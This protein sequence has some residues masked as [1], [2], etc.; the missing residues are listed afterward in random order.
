MQHSPIHS[1]R[2]PRHN[3]FPVQPPYRGIYAHGVEVPAGARTLHVSGQVGVTPSGHLAEGFQGQCLQAMDNVEAV[4]ASAEMTKEDIVKMSF[5]LTSPDN[6]EGLLSFRR[7]R[8]EGVQPAI[9]TLF[10][11]GLV[12]PS[13]LVEIEVTASAPARAEALN[14]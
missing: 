11:K 9:T 13:W 6:M 7:Q 3:P 10:V 2:S 1:S 12:D 14:S 5:F 4:L 8:L